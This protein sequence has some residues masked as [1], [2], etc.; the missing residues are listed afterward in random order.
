MERLT[1]SW[2]VHIHEVPLLAKWL[3]CSREL[4]AVVRA[5]A[6][7]ILARPELQR[8]FDPAQHRFARNEMEIVSSA[9]V[10]R[11]D[12]VVMFDDELWILDYKRNLFDSERVAYAA[13]LARYR[14]A[15]QDVFPGLKIRT[16]LITVDGTLTEVI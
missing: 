1:Q 7:T 11:F 3:P 4:A 14:V 8:F 6:D 10:A 16:A 2:P 13:Q 5:Q 15:A 9:G 12:R